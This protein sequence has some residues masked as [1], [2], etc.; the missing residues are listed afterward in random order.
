LDLVTLG[1]IALAAWVCLLIVIVAL[2]TASAR[3]D[4]GSERLFVALR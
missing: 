4:R 3:A 2:C 1:L